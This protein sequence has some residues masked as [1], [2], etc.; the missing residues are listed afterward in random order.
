ML[1]G[2]VL[3]ESN[4]IRK[5]ALRWDFRWLAGFIQRDEFEPSPGDL[6]TVAAENPAFPQ[7]DTS[8]DSH[9]I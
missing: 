9:A 7:S 6:L 8:R 2:S 3:L 5:F 1:P 4:M